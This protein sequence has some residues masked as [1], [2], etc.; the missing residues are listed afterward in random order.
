MMNAMDPKTKNVVAKVVLVPKTELSPIV[1]FGEIKAK[2]SVNPKNK[3]N[4][5]L[6][7]RLPAIK[8]FDFI[9]H[10]DLCL[11]FNAIKASRRFP[12]FDAN[13]FCLDRC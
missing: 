7:I 4:S 13:Q 10:L 1:I 12:Y 8:N 3:Q 9:F 5:P 2:I 6:M 11:F